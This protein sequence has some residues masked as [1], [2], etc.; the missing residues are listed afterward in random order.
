MFK[1]APCS[2][3]R[4]VLPHPM[5]EDFKEISLA[6]QTWG[7]RIETWGNLLFT[8]CLYLD[9]PLRGLC[10][11]IK[12]IESRAGFLAAPR[13]A[14]IGWLW[15]LTL[16]WTRRCEGAW[17]RERVQEKGDS[18]GQ[19]ACVFDNIWGWWKEERERESARS[20]TFSRGT[21]LQQP[22]MK[23][24]VYSVLSPQYCSI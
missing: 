18:R 8:A 3:K 2:R 11:L 13:Q 10:P 15:R 22:R 5:M 9:W 14:Q 20:K 4:L 23:P 17:E 1:C 21:R 16:L 12:S 7:R 19:T 6:T 24:V